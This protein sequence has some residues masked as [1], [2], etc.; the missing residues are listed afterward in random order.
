M[1]Q[2]SI[3]QAIRRSA[4]SLGVSIDSW[5]VEL[6]V[7][8]AGMTIYGDSVSAMV[9][10]SVAA[11]A[12]GKTVSTRH[13]LTGAVTPDGET[14]PIGSVPLKV[15]AAR[16]AKLRRVVVSKHT[17]AGET[18]GNFPVPIQ[19]SPVQSVP[20]ALDA[21]TDSPPMKST[22]IEVEQR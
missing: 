8:Y 6:S 22:I 20:E 19:V 17:P 2:T 7:P 12:Q 21:L 5:T 1:A 4:R 3:E 10:L 13:V 11:M 9:S 15:Q 14:G 16:A 18:A